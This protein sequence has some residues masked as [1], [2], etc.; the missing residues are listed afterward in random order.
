MNVS[1]VASSLGFGGFVVG[2]HGGGKWIVAYVSA[3]AC[4]WF[5]FGCYLEYD[6]ER[7]TRL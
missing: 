4:C 3:M 6:E 1:V 5:S 2:I 7:E